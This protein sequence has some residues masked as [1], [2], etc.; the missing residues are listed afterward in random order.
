MVAFLIVE[1]SAGHRAFSIRRR[2][3]GVVPVD[4]NRLPVLAVIRY[5]G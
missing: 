2:R 1:W 4:A 5:S 3:R